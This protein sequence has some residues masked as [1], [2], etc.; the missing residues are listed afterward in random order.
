MKRVIFAGSLALLSAQGFADWTGQGELG[1]VVSK[2]NS[3]TETA[4]VKVEMSNEI[5]D[6]K[7]TAGIVALYASQDDVDT[8]ERWAIYG[9]SDYS[10][11][12]KMYGFGAFRY[13]EDEFSGFDSQATF[14]GGVGRKFIDSET[15]K[16]SGTVGIGYRIL[17]TSDEV[18]D[19][20]NVITRGDTENEAIGRGTVNFE[21]VFT[22][23]TKLINAFVVETGS[24]NTFAENA[25]SL[26]VKMSDKLALSVG[27]TVRHN[28]EPPDGFV[29]TDKLTTIN[30][31]Y[32][33]K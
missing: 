31:V 25:T 24:S 21:H 10:F 20:G 14:S 11:T 26:Q 4:N 7:H 16:L 13:E 2:G 5:N 27:F 12:P 23:T 30:L 32:Q 1:L 15:T 18:D 28:S 17:E 9:E 3:E 33:I 6:W 19:L 22:E 29:S 8:A